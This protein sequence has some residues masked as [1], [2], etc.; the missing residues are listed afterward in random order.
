MINYTLYPFSTNIEYTKVLVKLKK[1]WGIL[2]VTKYI[3][4]SMYIST[5]NFILILYSLIFFYLE[6]LQVV[7]TRLYTDL[8]RRW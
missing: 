3:K 4:Q 5:N 2:G 7:R 6:E 1:A 8:H